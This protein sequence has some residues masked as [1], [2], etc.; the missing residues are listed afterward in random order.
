ML[1]DLKIQD[2]L[3]PHKNP[4][5]AWCWCFLPALI[6]F[7]SLLGAYLNAKPQLGGFKVYEDSLKSLVVSPIE[8]IA[9]GM[10]WTE[11]PLWIDDESKSQHYL[12]FSDTEQ[13][14]IW[15]YDEG[16]GFFSVGKS[17]RIPNSG[18]KINSTICE[19]LAEPGSN[20]LVRLYA[21]LNSGAD[22]VVCQHGERAV[23]ALLE[24]GTRILLATH[25][26]GKRLNSPNDLAWSNE[27]HLYFTD[28]TYGLYSRSRDVM[29]DRELDFSGVFMI[30]R[31]DVK[32]S[33]KTGK[34]TE[35]LKLITD[36][37]NLPNGITFSPG[38]IKAYVS[39]SDPKN[40]YWKVFDVS[41]DGTFTNGRVFFNATELIERGH[42]GNPDG[43][44]VDSR[45]NLFAS[46]P[47]GVLI[48]NPDGKLLGRL[49]TGNKTV[50][51]VA[52]GSNGVLYMTA[53]DSILRV[54]TSAKAAKLTGAWK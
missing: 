18:C 5:F 23:S 45:G 46:G 29:L 27:G 6:G 3:S 10:N 38:F 22:L 15:R 20:G 35:N 28:P 8:V 24:N 43:M 17:V 16:K 11:G 31:D 4:D 13:N 7:F 26:E 52:F 14:R 32:N 33:L 1:A 48:F 30:H 53:T 44:K 39:N 2:R 9:S 37:F 40:A 34:P 36:E 19:A 47:G 41:E 12:L 49:H 54:K 42:K 50:S 21:D 51:N 25:Y